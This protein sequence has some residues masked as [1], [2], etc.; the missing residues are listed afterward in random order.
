MAIGGIAQAQLAIA[1]ISPSPEGAV[2]L[3]TQA[4]WLTSRK[5]HITGPWLGGPGP[6]AG[7]GATPGNRLAGS[8]IQK[9]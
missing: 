3:Q 6:P 2:G 4:V 7:P 1:I 9:Q 5:G 8:I